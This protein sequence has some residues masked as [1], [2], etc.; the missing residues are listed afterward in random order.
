[1]TAE[2]RGSR[3]SGDVPSVLGDWTFDRTASRVSAIRQQIG[4]IAEKV[5]GQD[6]AGDVELAVGGT[7]RQHRAPW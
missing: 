4:A 1:M 5:L 3:P 7:T 2:E 6:R